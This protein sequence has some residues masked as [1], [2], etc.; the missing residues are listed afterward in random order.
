MP[1]RELID[2]V[3]GAIG[4]GFIFGRGQRYSNV[5]SSGAYAGTYASTAEFVQPHSVARALIVSLF[6]AVMGDE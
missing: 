2:F 1:D 3:N 4:R 5:L 6:D